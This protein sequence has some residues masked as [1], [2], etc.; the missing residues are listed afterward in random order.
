MKTLQRIAASIVVLCLLCSCTA[1]AAGD[2][3]N[4]IENTWAN[5][6]AGNQ[7][8]TSNEQLV[9]GTYRSFEM[10]Y[11]I[12]SLLDPN[13]SRASQLDII[14]SQYENANAIAASVTD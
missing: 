5:Y 11:I 2:Y 8:A 10:L 7:N 3:S 13:G 9:N 6:T 12:D 14:W 1:F 4:S